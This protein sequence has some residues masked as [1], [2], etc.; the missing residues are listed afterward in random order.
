M[1]T[2]WKPNWAAACASHV[3]DET[4]QMDGRVLNGEFLHGEPVDAPAR[5]V[6]ADILD[7]QHLIEELVESGRAN[8]RVEHGRAAIGQDARAHIARFDRR[9]RRLGVGIGLEFEIEHHE[10]V[11]EAWIVDP[12]EGERIV[13][14]ISR[15]MP[16]IRMYAHEA[17]KPGIF[18][19]L[20]APQSRKI[21]G[22]PADLGRK[23]RNRSMH[24]EQR[25]IGVEDA[26]PDALE[27][28]HG[29]ASL[30]DP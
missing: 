23:L 18:K 15:D 21:I 19:L 1:R 13:E 3:L 27:L 26:G 9:E 6:D 10:L 12:M 14:R 17:S 8:R 2:T 29:N 16:E 20:L 5:L 22:F 4:K 28:G 7:G 24:V 25:A 30:P 11:L